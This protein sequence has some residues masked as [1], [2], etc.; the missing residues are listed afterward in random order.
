[1][2]VSPMRRIRLGRLLAVHVVS[3]RAKMA[4]GR[5]GEIRLRRM[6]RYNAASPLGRAQG[7]PRT[8]HNSRCEATYRTPLAATGVE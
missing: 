7:P 3:S 4:L 8:A 2:G 1:M 5:T 6:P